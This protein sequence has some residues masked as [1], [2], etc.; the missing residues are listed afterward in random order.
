[1]KFIF[2]FFFSLYLCHKLKVYEFVLPLADLLF[3]T[4]IPWGNMKSVKS[5][6]ISNLTVKCYS[7]IS[8]KII[9]SI[10]ISVIVFFYSCKEGEIVEPILPVPEE[11]KP[12]R[13]DY[14]W[15]EYNLIIPPGENS[16][17]SSIWGAKPTDI[18]AVGPSS[19]SQLGIWHFNGE[20]WKNFI[21]NPTSTYGQTCIWGTDS[22]NIWLGSGGGIIWYYDGTSWNY[23]T[24]LKVNR[25]QNF[26]IQQIWGVSKN[27]IYAVGTAY[28][29]YFNEEQ[30]GGI[31]RFNGSE[32]K[33]IETP[34]Q[35]LY[36]FQF[37][38]S[39]NGNFLITALKGS[40]DST[41][42][43][44][45]NG[46]E[47]RELFSD[48][49]FSP[50]N[51]FDIGGK[52][53]FNIAKRIYRYEDDG[54]YTLWKDFTG[55]D[56]YSKVLCSRSEKDFFVGS[57]SLQGINHYNGNDIELIYYAPNTRVM[58]GL[59]F[60][61]DVFFTLL[62]MKTSSTRVVHGTLKE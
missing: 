41:K 59:I 2:F 22:N 37:A 57:W 17:L 36:F 52:T 60:E 1:L 40:V 55:T 20:T 7:K 28:N 61:K 27:E 19:L 50:I 11:I 58:A 38:K 49:G 39:I 32:W 45:W 54:K 25:Y 53:Y 26:G 3:P 15:K 33:Q 12:G 56:Y 35:Y 31:F 14:V 46:K 30:L 48:F 9:F 5:F 42:L 18:W 29:S 51:V 34:K 6:F 24:Q 23:Y 44:V 16:L 10:I 47:F 43:I 4:F 62:D 8:L 21:D 13:R